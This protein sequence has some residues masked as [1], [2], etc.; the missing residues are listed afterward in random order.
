MFATSWWAVVQKKAGRVMAGV[1][2]ED[3]TWDGILDSIRKKL[4][5]ETVETWFQA[6]EFRG[7]NKLRSVVQLSAPN[8]V[9][10]D[11]VTRNYSGLLDQSLSEVSLGGYTIEWEVANETLQGVTI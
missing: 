7:I 9:V 3:G 5:G 8:Q 11:W 6:I 10:R 1:I 2:F 4:N